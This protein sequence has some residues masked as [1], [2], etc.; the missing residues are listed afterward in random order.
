MYKAIIFD[1]DNTL[2][3][4]STCEIE[5]MK[6]TCNDHKLFVE[7]TDAWYLFYE[8]FSGHNFRHWLNFVSGGEVKTIG[9][10]L[11]YSFRDTLNLEELFHSKLSDTYWDY[12]CNSCYFEDGAEQILSS[13]KDKYDL[14]IISNG[15]SEAQRKRLQAGKIYE[16]FRSIMISDEVGIRKP[17]KEIFEMALKDLQLSNHEVLFVG[18]SL[19]DDYH[20][21]VNS[22]IDFCYY[23][24]QNIEVPNNLKPNYIISSLS[25][26]VDVVG[27]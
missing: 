13:F 2:I 17:N 12:F 5:A 23:N 1:L 21:A 3:N 7:D 16:M 27:L 11:R 20:G 19:Q 15:I 8:E 26:L 4:Y 9:E 25:E 24:R 18:D 14:G 10:V 22:E 6:R